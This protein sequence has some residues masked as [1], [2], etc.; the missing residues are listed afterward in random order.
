MKA[1][2]RP[3]LR[4]YG[5]W[6][7]RVID[8]PLSAA[9]QHGNGAERDDTRRLAA[10]QQAGNAPAAVRGHDD[11]IAAPRLCRLDDA[12]GGKIVHV[13][14]AARHVFLG[15]QRSRSRKDARGVLGTGFFIL[16]DGEAK[17]G[18]ASPTAADQGSV[19]VTTVTFALS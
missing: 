17:A 1:G 5:H 4:S 19:A 16:L 11:Q 10:E 7:A 6:A 12:V 9:D 18:A 13:H 3:F 15:G 2:A 14:G 8:A